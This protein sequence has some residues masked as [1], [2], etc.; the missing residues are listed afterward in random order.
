M[1]IAADGSLRQGC[2]G[3]DSL[4]VNVGK[5]VTHDFYVLPR[6]DVPGCMLEVDSKCCIVDFTA[7]LWRSVGFATDEIGELQDVMCLR[8]WGERVE[9]GEARN[10]GGVVGQDKIQKAMRVAV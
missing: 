5:S 7:Y 3:R 1:G 9:M 6:Y 4:V 10:S 2:V 8:A